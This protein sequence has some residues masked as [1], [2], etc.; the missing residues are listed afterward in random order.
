MEGRPFDSSSI[1]QSSPSPSVNSIPLSASSS[2]TQFSPSSSNVPSEWDSNQV[3]PS[4]NRNGSLSTPSF[5]QKT[6]NE[7]Y[8]A[9]KGQENASRSSKLTPSQGGRYQGFGSTST[10][11]DPP[12]SSG[13]P[14]HEAFI[15][16]PL[17]QLSKWGSMFASFA[18][19]TTKTISRELDEKVVK[20]T[21]I[22]V[23][24]G[25]LKE[26]VVGSFSQ[27]TKQVRSFPFHVISTLT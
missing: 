26:Q 4:V 5:S 1:P 16:D 2:T 3:L 20:P 18:V 19:K 23:R 17:G 12:P 14:P 8:F 9:T 7:S 10:S 21:S 13:L 6:Q 22:A 15:E 11:S 24:E 27:F 25:K